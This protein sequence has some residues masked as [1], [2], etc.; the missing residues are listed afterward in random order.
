MPR[1]SRTN[2][3]REGTLLIAAVLWLIGF[4]DLVLGVIALP[5]NLGLWALVIAGLLMI[6]ASIIYGL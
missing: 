5:N 2:P 1:R 6:L 3:P 4:A